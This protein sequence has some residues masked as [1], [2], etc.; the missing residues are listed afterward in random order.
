MVLRTNAAK[1]AF[2]MH[3]KSIGVDLAKSVFQAHSVDEADETVL[4]K[5]LQRKQMISFFSKLL[6]GL[7]GVEACA[8]AHD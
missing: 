2:E 4:V 3:I 1:G 6:P 7:I 5:K 8:T